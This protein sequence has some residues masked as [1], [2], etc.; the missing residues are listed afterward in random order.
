MRKTLPFNCHSTRIENR[1]GG[2]IPDVH[3]A[4]AGASF[5]VELKAPIGKTPALRPQQAAWHIRHASCG[6]LS[7]VICGFGRRPYLK[8]WRGSEAALAGSAG[9]LCVPA[10]ITC[11]G[12]DEALRLLFEDA[13]RLSAAASSAALRSAPSPAPAA[14]VQG[15]KAPGL[16]AGGKVAAP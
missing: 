9:L 14:A 2:G 3:L 12:M 10:L 6:G 7:Y 16:L 5:W 1:H 13:L 4:I 11:D 15:E 8:I